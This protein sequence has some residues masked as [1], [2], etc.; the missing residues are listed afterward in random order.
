MSDIDLTVHLLGEPTK[1]IDGIAGRRIDA[2]P[3]AIRWQGVWIEHPAT[4]LPLIVRVLGCDPDGW[5]V[6][7]DPL[8]ATIDL[9]GPI[10]SELVNPD[11]TPYPVGPIT[12]TADGRRRGF[13]IDAP[14]LSGQR[15]WV[16]D[17][18]DTWL[19]VVLGHNHDGYPVV[20]HL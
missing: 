2:D 13:L 3:Q 4:H 12:L 20:G 18:A 11:Q 7:P 6:V 1:T 14:L 9:R 15:L 5:P 10:L 16:T 17:G 19:Q 8:E